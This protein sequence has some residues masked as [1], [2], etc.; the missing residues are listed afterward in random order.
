MNTIKINTSVNAYKCI[1]KKGCTYTALCEIKDTLAKYDIESE[2]L[3]LGEQPVAG[4][5]GCEKCFQTGQCVF[6]DQVNEVSARLD[7]F[8]A[9]V[10]RSSVYYVGPSG[11]VTA[12]LDRLFY[13]SGRRMHGKPGGSGNRGCNL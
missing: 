8:D 10:I 11:Q 13:S 12:F 7:T 6:Q 2:I 9:V 4:Y 1:L 3:Y 5:I